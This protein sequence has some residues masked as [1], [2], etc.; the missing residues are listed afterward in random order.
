MSTNGKQSTVD[1]TVEYHGSISLFRPVSDAGTAWIAEH[2]SN[3]DDVQFWGS[4]LAVEHR[5]VESLA[6]QAI[7]DGLKVA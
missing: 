3:R 5:Y 7:E 2:F 4:A 6:K 1:L